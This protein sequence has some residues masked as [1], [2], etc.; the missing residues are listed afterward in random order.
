MR[1]YSP[2]YIGLIKAAGVW[3]TIRQIASKIVGDAE[4]KLKTTN[5]IPGVQR[6]QESN[7]KA[8]VDKPIKTEQDAVSEAQNAQRYQHWY[9]DR[10]KEYNREKRHQEQQAESI[11]DYK[12]LQQETNALAQRDKQM[13]DQQRAYANQ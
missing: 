6:N 9:S 8:E 7:E 3:D 1:N 5:V 4:P 11:Q 12:R 2:N 10:I 13:L